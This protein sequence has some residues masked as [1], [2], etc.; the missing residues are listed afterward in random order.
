MVLQFNGHAISWPVISSIIIAIFWVGGLTVTVKS[1][2]DDVKEHVSAPAHSAV[3]EI[4]EEIAS[5]KTQ[6]DNNTKSIDDIKDTQKQQAAEQA[7]QT[8]LL[9]QILQEVRKNE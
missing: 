3:H 5:L 7:T 2:A 6:Q 4:K 9:A 8:A 1:N